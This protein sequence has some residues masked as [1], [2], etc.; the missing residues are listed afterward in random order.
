MTQ[1]SHKMAQEQKANVRSPYGAVK[2]VD[3]AKPKAQVEKHVQNDAYGRPKLPKVTV[4]C[5]VGDC[6]QA[7]TALA[8]VLLSDGEDAS[9]MVGMPLTGL[10]ESLLHKEVSREIDKYGHVR[11]K[12][13]R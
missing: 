1:K 11:P 12:K 9:L 6:V 8:T 3:L 2:A 5:N 13:R 7:Q 10:T 4:D